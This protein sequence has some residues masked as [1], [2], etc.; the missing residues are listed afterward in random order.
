MIISMPLFYNTPYAQMG[1]LF[2]IQFF[3]ILRFWFVWPFVSKRR[4]Y[5]RLSLE[6]SL[7]LFFLVNL[8]QITLLQ[9]IMESDTSSM[10]DKI[11][12]FYGLGWAGFASCFYFNVTHIVIGLYDFCV[13]LKATNR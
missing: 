3:E 13:G 6:I 8:I 9:Q 11:A 2:I 12:L 7:L 5:I 1:I 10:G 4:N